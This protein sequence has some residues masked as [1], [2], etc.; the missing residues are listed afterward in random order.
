MIVDLSVIADERTTGGWDVQINISV[1]DPTDDDGRGSV[2]VGW[3]VPKSTEAKVIYESPKR[4]RTTEQSASHA[5]SVSRCPA[6]LNF[7]SRLFE[8][9]C[10]V[11]IAVSF[12]RHED[13]TAE[14][15]AAGGPH[16]SIRRGKLAQ[17][18]RMANEAE[19]R[20]PDRPILQLALPYIFVADAPV[21]IN[22]LAP[23]LYYRE[24]ALPGTMFAGRF[25]IHV[26][27]RP[28]MW[29]FEWHDTQKPL[30]IKRGDPLFYVQFETMPQERPVQL[31]EAELTTE[32]QEYLDL[33][34]GTVDYVS[35]TFSLM[36]AAADQRPSQLVV[37]KRRK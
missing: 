4:V 3:F 5:K 10:P 24:D 14:L 12:T 28:I 36:Q 16:S 33:I 22:Q 19:W 29:S 15:H 34:S 23:F 26:W 30:V 17:L 25:P 21:L 6:V 37:Q 13:G 7:Q 8:I 11:D 1:E 35:R 27:P 31:V 2:T 18:I 9:K 20:H 32:L